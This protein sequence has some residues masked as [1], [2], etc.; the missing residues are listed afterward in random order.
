MFVLLSPSLTVQKLHQLG[1]ASYGWRPSHAAHMRHGM[2]SSLARCWMTHGIL[3]F[4]GHI[5]LPARATFSKEF[6]ATSLVTARFAYRFSFSSSLLASE[7]PPRHLSR[8]KRIVLLQYPKCLLIVGGHETFL[9]FFVFHPKAFFSF[10]FSLFDNVEGVAS[11]SSGWPDGRILDGCSGR[12]EEV[13]VLRFH[14][15]VGIVLPSRDRPRTGP[16]TSPGDQVCSLVL[17]PVLGLVLGPVL[18]PVL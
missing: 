13:V 10:V 18:G 7:I 12:D 15:L 11:V 3:V 5:G 14:H 1:S 4:A 8:N 16:G 9:S 6:E 2:P 17:G